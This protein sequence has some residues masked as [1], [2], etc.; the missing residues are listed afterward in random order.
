ME[1]ATAVT[2]G[3]DLSHSANAVSAGNCKFSLFLCH[4]APSLGWPLSNLRKS[5]TDLPHSQWWRFGDPSSHHFWLIHPCD[6]EI[7][8]QTDRI[9]TAK[10]HYSN[11]CCCT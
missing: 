10:T 8:G 4:L 11:S 1:R 3:R 7:D 6:R 2:R 5:F 9:A